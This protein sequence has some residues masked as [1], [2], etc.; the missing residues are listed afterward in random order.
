MYFHVKDINET[1]CSDQGLVYCYPRPVNE[2][3]I[4]NIK[5]ALVMLYQLLSDITVSPLTR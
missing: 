3:L 4:Y 1:N 5:G 2:N